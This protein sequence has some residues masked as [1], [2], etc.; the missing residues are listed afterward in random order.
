MDDHKRITF[1]AIS[2]TLILCLNYVHEA[3]R[4]ADA[5][6]DGVHRAMLKGLIA[7]ASLKI[8]EMEKLT[9]IER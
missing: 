8:E 6:D 9:G 4:A 1:N 3:Y 7:A 5:E 2:E